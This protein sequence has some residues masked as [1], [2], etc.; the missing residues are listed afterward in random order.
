MEIHPDTFLKDLNRQ[1]TKYTCKAM[2]VRQLSTGNR[3]KPSLLI[4]HSKPIVCFH[5]SR[6]TLE[7]AMPKT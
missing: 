6:D 5:S 4:N 7:Q 3:Y 2:Q 1:A